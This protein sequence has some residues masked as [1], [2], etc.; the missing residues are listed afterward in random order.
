V[1]GGCDGS[2][3]LIETAIISRDTAKH[4]KFVLHVMISWAGSI[5]LH[6]AR[7]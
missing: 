4:L 5:R 2:A 3:K 6:R 1:K 7:P